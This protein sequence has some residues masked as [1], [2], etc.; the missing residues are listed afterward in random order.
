MLYLHRINAP[1]LQ[2]PSL[3]IT[4]TMWEYIPRVV[5]HEGLTY[6][7]HHYDVIAGDV[8][9]TETVPAHIGFIHPVHTVEIKPC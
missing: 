2:M 4:P 3:R 8:H 6:I 1:V 7:L 5:L 9:Y